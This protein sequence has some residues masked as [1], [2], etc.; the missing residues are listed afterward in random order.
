MLA[1]WSVGLADRGGVAVDLERD[2]S[3][4]RQITACRFRDR[5][6]AQGPRRV[7]P[8]MHTAGGLPALA[9][10]DAPEMPRAFSPDTESGSVTVWDAT[11]GSIRLPV[12]LR[13]VGL[14]GSGCLSG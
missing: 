10:A 1:G 3:I 5:S 4:H 6:A 11:V 7:R 9:Y 2:G 8:S 14:L 13:V 12:V